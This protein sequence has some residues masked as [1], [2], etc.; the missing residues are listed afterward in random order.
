M[1]INETSCVCIL[2][3]NLLHTLYFITL[4]IWMETFQLLSVLGGNYR[5]TTRM[6]SRRPSI[7]KFFVIIKGELDNS[8]IKAG[9]A[10]DGLLEVR[11]N[12]PTLAVIKTRTKLKTLLLNNEITLRRFL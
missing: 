2:V 11:R 12:R 8:E 6:R 4:I 9:Q 5:L 1:L 10:L 7:Y 3:N